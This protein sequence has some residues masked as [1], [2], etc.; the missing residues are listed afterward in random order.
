MVKVNLNV[1][2][3]VVVKITIVNTDDGVSD[4]VMAIGDLSFR[5]IAMKKNRKTST[6]RKTNRNDLANAMSFVSKCHFAVYP[7][8]TPLPQTLFLVQ[9][10]DPKM[11]SFLWIYLHSLNIIFTAIC[12][13][14]LYLSLGIC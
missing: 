6:L 13:P 9:T 11:H 4:W 3:K 14:S 12:P 10:V 2:G 8:A 5:P 7:S 1:I